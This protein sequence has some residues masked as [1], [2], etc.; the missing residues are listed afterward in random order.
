MERR[1]SRSHSRW[2]TVNSRIFSLVWKGDGIDFD[3]AGLI[4]LNTEFSRLEIT[5]MLIICYK[6]EKYGKDVRI[7]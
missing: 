1:L 3:T 4:W 5:S 2:L 7:K 6:Y